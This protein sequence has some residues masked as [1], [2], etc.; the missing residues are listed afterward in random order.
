MTPT[1]ETCRFAICICTR[2]RPE[3][4]HRALVSIAAS[5][6][7]ASCVVVSD[8]STDGRTRAMITGDYPQIIF[9]EGPRLGLGANRNNALAHAT[10]SHVLFIDDDVM[11]SEH[12]L[13]GIAAEV[14][15]L[16]TAADATILT[17]A[18]INHGRRV[19]AHRPSFFGYQA[20]GYRAQD[21]Y[22]TIVINSAVFPIGLFGHVKFDP[23]LVYGCDEMDLTARAILLHGFRVRFLPDLA[24]LH[25]PS[26]VN[27]DYYAPFMEASRI[28]VQFKRFYWVERKPA[29][30]ALFLLLAYAHMLLHYLKTRRLSG[31]RAFSRTVFLSLSYIAACSGNRS[32][33]V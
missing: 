3:D 2:N 10:G 33:Y 28:Y 11:L 19:V 1:E 8:D 30:A 7:A 14:A 25:F 27:R 29:K 5:T 18:E 16:G 6:V 9:V 20:V 26:E 13:E 24:N 17:G 15:R 23:S 12:F 32:R 4:L 21:A 31:L 22:E